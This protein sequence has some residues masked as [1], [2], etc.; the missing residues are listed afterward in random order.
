M[1]SGPIAQAQRILATA[2]F[3]LEA[4]ATYWETQPSRRGQDIKDKIRRSNQ[5]K[6]RTYLQQ[7]ADE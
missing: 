5:D 4:A 1:L 6:A 2:Q 3:N 7:V